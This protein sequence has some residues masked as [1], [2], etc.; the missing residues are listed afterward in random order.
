MHTTRTAVAVMLATIITNHTNLGFAALELQGCKVTTCTGTEALLSA[1]SA[2][3]TSTTSK[4][5]D[6][7]YL[8]K[9]CS[10]CV[11][12][13]TLTNYS[14]SLPCGGLAQMYQECTKS[15]SS[16][17]DCGAPGEWSCSGAYCHRTANYCNLDKG[18]GTIVL[19]PNTCKTKTEYA[20]N[21]GYYGTTTNG[22]SGCAR[23]PSSDG[24]YGSSLT[25]STAITLCY[26]PSG[27]TGSDTTGAFTYT[28]NSYYCN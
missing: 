14:V 5:Y 3:C 16:D 27:T 23:C 20:C 12:G 2:W 19:N 22:L 4:C 21:A 8:V 24:I 11:S 17:S 6:N 1:T 10:A 9:S 26:M 25:A 15:C 7:A 28:G 18:D 13:Y